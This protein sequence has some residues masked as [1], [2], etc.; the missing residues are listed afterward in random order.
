MTMAKNTT[1]ASTKGEIGNLVTIE[2]A[3]DPSF[4]LTV[5]EDG[6][7][8]SLLTHYDAYIY[9]LAQK[10][11]P[12]QFARRASDDEFNMEVD[13][14]VQRSRIKLWQALQ[15]R[16]VAF[17]KAYIRNIVSSECVDLARQHKSYMPLPV[18]DDGELYQ[19]NILL[20]VG[21]DVSDPENILVQKESHA[22]RLKELIN[23]VL[24]RLTRRQKQA[25]LY[26]LRE[27]IDDVDALNETLAEHELRLEDDICMP[28]SRA[29]RRS[30]QASCSQARRKIAQYMQLDSSS[31]AYI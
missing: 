25:F 23:I 12:H 20:T 30:L 8:N 17:P 16:Q 26:G 19:G 22:E 6:S 29:E 2:M 31:L 27:K 4:A 13:E 28:A 24:Y 7:I 1:L 9:A 11:I 3:S 5:S 18:D 21:E 14:L 10:S 15:K